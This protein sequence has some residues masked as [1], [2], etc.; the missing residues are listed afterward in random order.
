MAFKNIKHESVVDEIIE[1]FK[2]KLISG[3]L[4]PGQ[5]LPSESE[6]VEQLGVG[7]SALREAIKMLSALGVVDVRRGDG[8]YIVEEVSSE[9][10]NELVFQIILEAGINLEL[11]GLRKLL[12]IGYCRLCAE[13]ASAGDIKIIEKAANNF[14]NLVYRDDRNIEQ[15]TQADLNFHYSIID[16]TKNLLVIR[17][18]RAVEEMFFGSIRNTVSNIVRQQEGSEGHRKILT[19]IK[20]RNPESIRKAVISSLE[21]L[22]K[23]LEASTI[24]EK[25][26]SSQNSQRKEDYIGESNFGKLNLNN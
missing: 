3:D 24:K 6:L 1:V 15:L 17:I 7:R 20:E 19:A 2:Q 23:D 13:K 22:S 26:A 16:A 9:S 21:R 14:E 18:C 25:Q 12:Q 4:K 10:L 8:T 11:L 5:K